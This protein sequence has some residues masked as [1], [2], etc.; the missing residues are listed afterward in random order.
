M[1]FRRKGAD[2]KAKELAISAANQQ[3]LADNGQGPK[4]P[5]IAAEARVVLPRTSSVKVPSFAMF[6]KNIVRRRASSATS[7]IIVNQDGASDS[8][9]SAIEFP[10]SKD[11]LI[12]IY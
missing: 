7:D 4:S 5:T 8:S 12:L 2:K 1:S 10:S 3:I 11:V 9:E 6:A